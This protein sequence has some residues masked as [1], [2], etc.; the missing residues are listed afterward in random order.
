MS[1][2]QNRII[3]GSAEIPVKTGFTLSKRLDEELDSA[4]L[5]LPNTNINTV[6]SRLTPVYIELIGRNQRETFYV[7]GD[8]KTRVANDSGIYKHTISL[9]EPIKYLEKILVPDLQFPFPPNNEWTPY[10]ITSALELI[11]E[12]TPLASSNDQETTRL[13]QIGDL[14]KEYG[15]VV[16]PEIRLYKNNMREA[17]NKILMNIDAIPRVI[18]KNDGS[19]ELTCDFVNDKN[20]LLDETGLFIDKESADLEYYAD[21]LQMRV[22]NATQKYKTVSYPSNSWA[23]ISCAT[24]IVSTEDLVFK[25]PFPI[26]EI[27]KLECWISVKT[28]L[29]TTDY[30]VVDLTNYVVNQDKYISLPELYLSN[31]KNELT[32]GSALYYNVGENK[33]YNFGTLASRKN[34]QDNLLGVRRPTIDY[35][36]WDINDSVDY[37]VWDTTNDSYYKVLWRIQYRTIIETNVRVVRD[38]NE[39][40]VFSQLN[41]NQGENLVDLQLIGENSRGVINKSGLSQFERVKKCAYGSEY[42]IGDYTLDNKIVTQ[43]ENQY[44]DDHVISSCILNPNFNQISKRVGVDATIRQIPLPINQAYINHIYEDYCVV[45]NLARSGSDNLSSVTEDY[46]E[47]FKEYLQGGAS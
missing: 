23:I 40:F 29:S 37:P 44:Y 2:Q 4:I 41:S 34:W 30:E 6:F 31:Y 20:R 47:S 15:E 45:D 5:I 14:I 42:Q 33:I 8:Q 13:V 9:I 12:S 46:L 18:I 7:A 28:G 26:H 16:I 43:T 3:I 25:T 32:K 17:F 27:L 36:L 21:S 1:Y 24:D 22:D 10:T 19:L 11:I 39:G 38:S 35:I